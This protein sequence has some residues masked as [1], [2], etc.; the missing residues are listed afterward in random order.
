MDNASAKYVINIVKFRSNP[1]CANVF[2]E[3]SKKFKKHKNYQKFEKF[4]ELKNPIKAQKIKKLKISENL[5]LE[6]CKKVCNL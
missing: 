2:R 6:K 1:G 3:K 4:D 5:S